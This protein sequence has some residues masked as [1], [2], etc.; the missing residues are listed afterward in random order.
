MHTTPAPDVRPQ[1]NVLTLY[2]QFRIL[3]GVPRQSRFVMK[4][5][6]DVPK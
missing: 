3:D 5:G 2:V 6:D 1:Y 4:I